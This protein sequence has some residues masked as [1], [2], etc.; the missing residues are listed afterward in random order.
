MLLRDVLFLIQKKYEAKP[1]RDIRLPPMPNSQDPLAQVWLDKEKLLCQ[2]TIRFAH[3]V[4]ANTIL[5]DSY[6]AQDSA[7]CVVYST[8]SYIDEY[9]EALKSIAQLLYR[10]KTMPTEFVP[11]AHR[12]LAAVLKDEYD[13]SVHRISLL[14]GEK[15]VEFVVAP[16]WIF[17]HLLPKRKLCGGFLPVLTHEECNSLLTV[18]K[19]YWPFDFA[20]RWKNGRF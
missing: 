6:P 11:L 7:A 13:R 3:I 4:Q 2:G 19:E 1:P 9:P 10:Y 15:M 18:P 16:M 14:C 20:L 8:D 17:R 12:D 5:F